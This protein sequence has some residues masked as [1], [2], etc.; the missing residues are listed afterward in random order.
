MWL[1]N[2]IVG[3]RL[4]RLAVSVLAVLATVFG[5]IQYGRMTEKTKQ[6]TQELKEYR[7]TR[8]RIDDAERSPDRD[9]ALERMRKNNQLR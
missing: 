3:S 5:L 7:K 1:F 6:K 8:E 4:K 9:A 2:L